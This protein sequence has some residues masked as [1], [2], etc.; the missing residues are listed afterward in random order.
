MTKANAPLSIIVVGA[1]GDLAK[2]KIFPALFAL[3]SQGFL[4]DE[5]NI[6]GFSRSSFSHEEFR[7]RIAEHLTCRYVPDHSCEKQMSEFLAHCTYQAGK[8]DNADSFLDLYQM[9][10]EKE[11]DVPANRMFYLAIPPDLFLDV[12]KTIGDAGLVSCTVDNPWSRV[13]IEKPFGRDQ[14]SSDKLTRELAKVFTESQT[15]RIDHYLGKEVVQNLMVLRFA[16]LFFEPIWNEKHIEFVHINWEED[17]GIGSRGGY[18]D[19]YGVIRDVVQNHL[20]QILALVAMERPKSARAKDIRNA[21]VETLKHIAPLKLSDV[22][23]GQYVGGKLHG[24]THPGYRKEESTPDNSRTPTYAAVALKIQNERWQGVPFVITAGKALDRRINEIRIRFKEIP[25]NI[26]CNSPKCL[27]PNELV[28]RIQPDEALYLNIVSK[29][30]GL[31]INLVETNLNLKYESEFSDPIPDAYECLLLDV[32]EG[33]KGLFIRADELEAAWN[34]FTPILHE[35][36]KK[37]ITPD[38][39][40]FGTAGGSLSKALRKQHGLI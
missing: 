34:I 35:I 22:M 21:K 33:D 25:E 18:Y 32:I 12:A 23:L 2:K 8:Y 4:P 17:M 14:A 13:V 31:D 9:I 38:P 26:F 30:P 15:Y 36:E 40:P 29:K 24:V 10:Q 11:Q 20:L 37:S 3:Y 6:F 19:Q 16:N 28:V 27:P 7:A 1:S 5:F 39:Y